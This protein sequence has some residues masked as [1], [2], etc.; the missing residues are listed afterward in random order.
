MANLIIDQFGSD[1][2]LR[3]AEKGYFTVKVDVSV[4]AQFLS[5]VIALEGKVK[6]TGPDRVKEDMKK[7][8]KQ[9]YTE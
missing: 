5:W 2:S 4:S 6:I 8:L 7:L 9:K 3:P 1:V